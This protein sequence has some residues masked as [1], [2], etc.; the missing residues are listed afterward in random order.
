MH[1]HRSLHLQEIQN[2]TVPQSF[3]C[4]P[5]LILFKTRA[6]FNVISSRIP[7]SPI[8]ISSHNSHI[9]P[10]LKALSTFR[11]AHG[12]FDIGVLILYSMFSIFFFC[13]RKRLKVLTRWWMMQHIFIG[14]FFTCWQYKC[15]F[16]KWYCNKI[17]SYLLWKCTCFENGQG[18]SVYEN[19]V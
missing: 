2:W 19:V 14:F 11:P 4:T 10:F 7:F 18:P 17:Q 1:I 16:W 6:L 12:A 9:H 15:L 5:S 3:S 8:S 13:Q